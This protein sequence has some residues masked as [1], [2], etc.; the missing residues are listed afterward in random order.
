MKNK[1]GTVIDKLMPWI[2]PVLM[3][4]PNLIFI[5]TESVPAM[6]KLAGIFMPLGIYACIMAFARRT[7]VAVLLCIPLMVFN[8]FQI[9]LIDL[10]GGG[11]IGVDMFLNVVTTSVSEAS[12]LLDNMWG[13]LS[14]ILVL[15]LPPIIWAIMR[16][17]RHAGNAPRPR[18]LKRCAVAIICAGALLLAACYMA[19]P[20]YSVRRDLFPVNIFTNVVEAVSRTQRTADYQSTSKQF[21]HHASPTHADSLKEVYVLVVGETS[22]AENWSLFGHDRPTNPL[23]SQQPGLIGF[24]K[25][26]SESNTTHKSVP[27][28]LSHLDSRNFG[29]SI[30]YTKSVINAFNEAGFRTSFLSIQRPNHSFIDFFGEQAND[31]RFLI[32]EGA[33]Q[34]DGE[35]EHAIIN[36]IDT[37][38]ANKVFIVAH[39]YGS[40]FNYRDRYPQEFEHFTPTDFISASPECRDK[41]INAYDNTIRYTDSFLNSII[42]GLDSL[43]AA[44]ALVYLSDHGEDIYDDSRMRFLHASPTPTFHQLHVPMLVWMS[45]RYDEIFPD[46]HSAAVANQHKQVSSTRAAFHTIL[47]LAG[48]RSPYFNASESLASPSYAEPER[49]YVD[50][51]NECVSLDKSGL[52]EVDLR[53]LSD[54][55][56]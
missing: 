40:H 2:F 13:S 3:V 10:Y 39:S 5:F 25:T 8:A 22:R 6:Y 23:L 34:F 26:L 28:I 47:D 56:K 44:S 50:D 42:A 49:T 46:K 33:A 30:Y 18:L 31:S 1:I 16:C 21:S 20:K 55:E 32:N 37:V 14:V 7:A 17:V 53:L 12:E 19:Y 29:D 11:I 48:I 15:Y 41:L 4:V 43:H 54:M 52:K 45:G 24:P 38:R 27:M 35:L 9:V 36:Y 51:Y